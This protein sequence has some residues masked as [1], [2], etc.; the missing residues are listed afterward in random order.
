M[1]DVNLK[2]YRYRDEV[3][4]LYGGVC[5]KCRFADT[6]ALQLDHVNGGGCQERRRLGTATIYKDALRRAG[7]GT[8][9]LLCANCNWIKRVEAGEI[10]LHIRVVEGGAG[11]ELGWPVGLEPTLP[12]SQSGVL[13][14]GRQPRNLPPIALKSSCVHSAGPNPIAALDPGR[15]PM[16]NLP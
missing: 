8:Y 3:L 9:Q 2:A 7:D 1:R 12:E 10:K 13:P 15:G 5:H 16:S 14:L 6:R 11:V 4:R